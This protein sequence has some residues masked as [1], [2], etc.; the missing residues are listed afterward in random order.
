MVIQL[1]SQHNSENQ[2]ENEERK[3]NKMEK[4]N[5]SV[6]RSRNKTTRFGA[7]I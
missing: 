7:V 3:N 4:E 1:A 5:Q 2:K 6:M